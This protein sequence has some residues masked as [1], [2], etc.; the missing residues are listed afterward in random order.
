M[1]VVSPPF[2][3]HGDYDVWQERPDRGLLEFWQQIFMVWAFIVQTMSFFPAMMPWACLVDPSQEAAQTCGQAA[4]QYYQRYTSL[5]RHLGNAFLVSL[6]QLQSLQPSRCWWS[7]YLATTIHQCGD[8]QGALLA[9]CC[10]SSRLCL[11][12]EA[13]LKQYVPRSKQRA[14]IRLL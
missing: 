9:G 10:S 3:P 14:R 8:Q 4:R 6:S 2:V 13:S 7:R 1:L 12:F 5:F 11:L